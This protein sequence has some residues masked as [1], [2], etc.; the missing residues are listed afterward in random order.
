MI[1]RSTPFDLVHV[2]KCGGTSIAEELRAREF[3]FDH[4]HLRRPVAEPGRRYVVLTRDPVARFVSA[5]NWRRHLLNEDLLPAAHDDDLITRLRH[6][7]EREFL[8]AFDDANQLAE[9][10]VQRGEYEVSATA[11][12]M[13]LIGHVPQGFAWYLGDL[14]DQIEPG[15]LGGVIATERLTDDSEAVFG[16]RPTLELNRREALPGTN[17][18]A[19]GRANLAREFVAEYRILDRLADLACRAG[20]PPAIRYD[21]VRGAVPG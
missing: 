14:L 15:Q 11:T 16:F 5:F 1:D 12:L 7:A 8:A 21:A 2:G 6:R 4:V 17:L 10:L 19:A 13:Q 3:R 18:S 20:V 9:R